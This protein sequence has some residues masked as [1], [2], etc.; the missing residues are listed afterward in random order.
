MFHVAFL[1]VFVASGTLIASCS[2][3]PAD[4]VPPAQAISTSSDF[5]FTQKLNLDDFAPS[6]RGRDLLIQNC[7]VCHS[8]VCAIRGQR[9]MEHFQNVM[10]DMRSR[11][12]S[13]T[14]EDYDM[15]F[16]YLVEN[17]SDTKPEP[18][19]PPQLS[20]QGCSTGAQ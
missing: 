13:I 6:G 17:F 14:D 7:N 1:V 9:T 2:A 11:V 15:L 12:T 20:Q 19:L 10:R 3:V 16:A 18:R 8:F 4:P 5:E